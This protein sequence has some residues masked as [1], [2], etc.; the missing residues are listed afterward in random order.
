MTRFFSSSSP[1]SSSAAAAGDNVGGGHDACHRV[2]RMTM[3]TFSSF[4]FIFCRVPLE[5][6]SPLKKKADGSVRR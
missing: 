3:Q 4:L 1:S 6:I 5:F 2:E